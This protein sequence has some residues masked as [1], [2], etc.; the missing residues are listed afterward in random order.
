MNNID[1]AFE[2]ITLFRNINP[3]TL[4]K[5]KKDAEVIVFKNNEQIFLQNTE[6]D[7]LYIICEGSGYLQHINTESNSSIQSIVLAD[8]CFNLSTVLLGL[9]EIITS[10]SAGKTTLLC[11]SKERFLSAQQTDRV[12]EKNTKTLLAIEN[13]N[14]LN[15]TICLTSFDVEERISWFCLSLILHERIRKNDN[16]VNSLTV[17][18]N[19]VVIASYLNM[20]PETLSR[21][22]KKI[23]KYGVNFTGKN[24]II[25]DQEKACKVCNHVIGAICARKDTDDC[26]INH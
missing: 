4:K 21:A 3:A 1:N 23:D 22:I 11:V 18:L 5:L 2:Q 9:T 19:K 12:L 10:F 6:T 20:K 8:S 24:I 17:N 15:H 26:P 16:N 25:T 13:N 14:R 7:F